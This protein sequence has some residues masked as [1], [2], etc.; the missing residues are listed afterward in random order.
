MTRAPDYET[1]RVPG[2]VRGPIVRADDPP[3]SHW[4]ADRI[5]E[6]IQERRERLIWKLLITHLPTHDPDMPDGLAWHTS[7]DIQAALITRLQ[8][9]YALSGIRT[10]LVELERQDL[11]VS[12]VDRPG[13]TR[14]GR[15]CKTYRLANQFIGG[16]DRGA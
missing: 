3:T 8:T 11:I 15:A 14:R 6:S 10:A 2:H 12:S 1:V 13:R 5:P 4:A 7:E 16:E 9:D